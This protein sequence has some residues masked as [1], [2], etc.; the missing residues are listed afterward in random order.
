M[1]FCKSWYLSCITWTRQ[2]KNKELLKYEELQWIWLKIMFHWPTSVKRHFYQNNV[3][4]IILLIMHKIKS[5]SFC[6]PSTALRKIS[7]QRHLLSLFSWIGIFIDK[8]TSGMMQL[9]EKLKHIHSAKSAKIK[10]PD[11]KE[12]I[13][14]VLIYK[15][16][17][18]LV[19]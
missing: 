3:C 4:F 19:H 11:L 9:M 1:M 12:Y 17:L 7:I 5:C 8:M 2:K 15:I 13:G 10:K 14:S 6:L 18:F 16:L